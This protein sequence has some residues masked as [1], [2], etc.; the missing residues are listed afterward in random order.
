[1]FRNTKF[2]S[3]TGILFAICFSFYGF[4]DI[5]SNQIKNENLNNSAEVKKAIQKKNKE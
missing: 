2:T 3:V 5:Q 4:T 1:M